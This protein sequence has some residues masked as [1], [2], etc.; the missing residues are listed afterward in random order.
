MSENHGCPNCGDTGIHACIGHKPEPMTEMDQAAFRKAMDMVKSALDDKDS[1]FDMADK[2]KSAMTKI[3]E[4]ENNL[5][6]IKRKIYTNGE[7]KITMEDR[8]F[9]I[10]GDGFI[11]DNNFDFDAGLQVSG[12]FVDDEKNEYA[13]MIV[14]ALNT[15]SECDKRVAMMN[16]RIDEQKHTISALNDCIGGE[17]S[18]TTENLIRVS[19]LEQKIEFLTRKNEILSMALQEAVDGMGGSYAI[20]SGK[21][22][23]ALDFD[24]EE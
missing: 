13:Q 24:G 8:F 20:W 18:T 3:R 10:E 4:L 15:V 21:A 12:D 7:R 11:L 19:R 17:G 5:L 16:D 1:T 6:E 22:K 9:S 14:S 2:L 23:D